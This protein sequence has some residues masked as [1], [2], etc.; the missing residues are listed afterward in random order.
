MIFGPI[1]ADLVC[2]AHSRGV[3]AVF[4]TDLALASIGVEPDETDYVNS[5]VALQ[6][7][8]NTDGCVAT[9]VS[10]SSYRMP[11]P[12]TAT[13]VRLPSDDG[14][15]LAYCVSRLRTSCSNQE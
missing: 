5:V 11:L 15:P 10:R 2:Y 6:A 13:V 14:K 9:P 1:S 4:G 8:K 3:R 12:S 7:A